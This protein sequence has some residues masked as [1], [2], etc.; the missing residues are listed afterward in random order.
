MNR[1]LARYCI[2]VCWTEMHW[3][4]RTST[5]GRRAFSVAGPAAWNC[6]SDELH[7]PL[8]TANS[9]RQ[10]LKTRLFS[11]SA[12]SALEVLH[13]MLNLLT[14]LLKADQIYHSSTLA[15]YLSAKTIATD[16]T[17]AFVASNL[18]GKAKPLQRHNI[19]GTCTTWLHYTNPLQMRAQ[20]GSCE[21]RIK[22]ILSSKCSTFIR[23]NL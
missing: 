19:I 2:W 4:Y 16:Y 17:I 20:Q 11:T 7:E 8:L 23:A 21:N 6:L 15:N 9:F 5:Y 13:I 10:L 1:L 22:Q 3:Q 18:D 12:Y 14:Y